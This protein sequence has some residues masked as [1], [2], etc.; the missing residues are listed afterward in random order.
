MMQGNHKALNLQEKSSIPWDGWFIGSYTDPS[1]GHT[2]QI[3][4]Q[5]SLYDG[6]T[7]LGNRVRIRSSY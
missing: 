7:E 1:M 6:S 3:R 4:L 2:N 5:K